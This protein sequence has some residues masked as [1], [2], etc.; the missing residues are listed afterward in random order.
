MNLP[1]I[2]Q[3]AAAWPDLFMSWAKRRGLLG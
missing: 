1:A 3:N 2:K